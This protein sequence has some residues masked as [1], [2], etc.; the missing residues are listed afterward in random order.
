M[1]FIILQSTHQPKKKK[2]RKNKNNK[3]DNKDDGQRDNEHGD[4][5]PP[6]AQAAA[7]F[8]GSNLQLPPP[9]WRSAAEPP[10]PQVSLAQF[11]PYLSPN[12]I[13]KPS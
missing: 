2:K 3:D 11:F 8:D 9:T 5:A 10:V 6:P 4:N 13:C 1:I 7:L 12:S